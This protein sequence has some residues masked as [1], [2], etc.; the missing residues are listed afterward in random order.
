MNDC[1]AQK[2]DVVVCCWPAY[3]VVLTSGLVACSR[4]CS[5]FP[6]ICNA[7]G[8]GR[9]VC[10]GLYSN[11][12]VRRLPRACS[13]TNQTF[14]DPLPL[15]DTLH[16]TT[17]GQPDPVMQNRSGATD[18]NSLQSRCTVRTVHEAISRFDPKKRGLV[19][20]MG[21]GGLLSIPHIKSTNRRFSAWLMG[22]VDVAHPS[23]RFRDGSSISFYKSD[24][25]TV[26]GIPASRKRIKEAQHL[27]K[28]EKQRMKLRFWPLSGKEQH[29]IRAVQEVIERIY[30][31]G[32]SK[33]QEDAFKVAFVVFVMSTL[34]V[35][36][37]KH[38]YVCV[39]YWLALVDADTIHL[40]DWADY[41]LHR[42]LASVAK[43]QT[44][45][46]AGCRAPNVTGCCL[47][48]QVRTNHVAI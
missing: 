41:I 18:S 12:D 39:D 1:C 28:E 45:T 31:D 6:I 19:E 17:D 27:S 32:M 46:R 38:D 37:A 35:P 5:N 24:V 16:F 34:F 23:L 40:F 26:F 2:R 14:V 42:L 9:R 30:P 48:L 15:Q 43:F 7:M 10:S 21:F 22:M 11:H 4:P 8:A 13:C 25:A 3:N 33:D 20:A 29:S 36:G 44:D 47:F